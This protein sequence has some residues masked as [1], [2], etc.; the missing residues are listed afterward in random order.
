MEVGTRLEFDKECDAKCDV[1]GKKGLKPMFHID[2]ATEDNFS[3]TVQIQFR[4][5]QKHFKR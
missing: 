1:C 3:A 5:C 2:Y 4:I